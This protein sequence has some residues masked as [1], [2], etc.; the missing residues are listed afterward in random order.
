MFYLFR[1]R[2]TENVPISNQANKINPG[3]DMLYWFYLI[4]LRNR[5]NSRRSC[6]CVSRGINFAS[7][8]YLDIGFWNSVDSGVFFVFHFY[9]QGYDIILGR[10]DIFIW[11]ISYRET[12][13]HIRVLHWTWKCLSVGERTRYP[14]IWLWVNTKWR[15]PCWRNSWNV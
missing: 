9:Y 13:L 5:H 6:I 7:L 1:R 12:L 2:K 15:P 4:F 11:D 3:V 8:Y 10:W 14:T